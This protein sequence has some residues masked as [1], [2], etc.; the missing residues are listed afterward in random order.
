M[1]CL[2]MC[3]TGSILHVGGTCCQLNAV[4]DSVMNIYGIMGESSEMST[5][6]GS[7]HM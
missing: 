2:Q 4:V 3:L 5:Q 1:S 6:I 7:I